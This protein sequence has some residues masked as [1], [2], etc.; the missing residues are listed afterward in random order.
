M[1]NN[2]GGRF[3]FN[4]MLGDDCVVDQRGLVFPDTHAAITAAL[5][6]SNAILKALGCRRTG[7]APRSFEI[8][9]EDGKIVAKVPLR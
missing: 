8:T 7:R 3:F 6:G 2:E 9:D 4:V 1:N 5:F